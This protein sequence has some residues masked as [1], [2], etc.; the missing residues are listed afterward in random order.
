MSR[1]ALL[2]RAVRPTG[3]VARK[4]TDDWLAAQRRSSTQKKDV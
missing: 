1:E 3:E 2:G 4:S